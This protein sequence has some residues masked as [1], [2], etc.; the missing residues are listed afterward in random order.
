MKIIRVNLLQEKDEKL[1]K[2]WNKR[3]IPSI[4]KQSPIT[5]SDYL[6][7]KNLE[8]YKHYIFS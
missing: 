3:E 1:I 6:K 8:Q 2:S 7:K 5:I 4:R